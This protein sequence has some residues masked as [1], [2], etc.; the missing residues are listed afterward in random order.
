MK[1]KIIYSTDDST[2]KW[3][4]RE[5]NIQGKKLIGISDFSDMRI[6]TIF[7]IHDRVW[8]EYL[9]N[10]VGNSHLISSDRFRNPTIEEYNTFSI[11]LK[12]FGYKYNKKKDEFIK[13][14]HDEH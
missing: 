12:M 2:E 13:T 14:I 8:L 5:K 11:I 10:G 9:I 7:S 1:L 3:I 4:I 6:N